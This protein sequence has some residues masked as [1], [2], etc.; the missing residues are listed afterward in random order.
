MHQEQ[1]RGHSLIMM[2]CF[3]RLLNTDGEVDVP[4][5]NRDGLCINWEIK[6]RNRK[7]Y[8]ILRHEEVSFA[9]NGYSNSCY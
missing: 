1:Y 7:V 9:Q 2:Y 3:N 8:G 5:C 4:N 6:G